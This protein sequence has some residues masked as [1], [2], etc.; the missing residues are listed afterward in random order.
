[1]PSTPDP[2]TRTAVRVVRA[3]ALLAI[4]VV[5]VGFVVLQDEPDDE[6]APPVVEASTTLPPGVPAAVDEL[7]A[8]RADAL[9]AA[10]GRHDAVVSLISYRGVESVTAIAERAGVEV[11]AVLV[12]PPGGPPALVTASLA[13]WIE[14][15]RA[16]ATEERAALAEILPT[17]DPGD[18]FA[19][20]YLEDI[21]R[22]DAELAGLDAGAD[23]I[24]GFTTTASADALRALALRAD[25]RLVDVDGL[26]PLGLRPEE[27]T[28]VGEPPTRS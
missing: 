1:M 25:V 19:A 24:Y 10:D 4:G 2:A 15:R 11:V 14:E 6:R 5:A 18:P 16:A 13:D 20:A 23:L 28:R 3:L 7:L 9:A 12:A 27:V 22:L 17:V 26:L 21:A 8:D